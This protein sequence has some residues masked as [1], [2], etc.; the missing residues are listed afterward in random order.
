MG[1]G[2]PPLS[3]RRYWAMSSKGEH[4]L[5]LR[6]ASIWRS[7]RAADLRGQGGVGL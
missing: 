4:R 7:R 5:T 6:A 1:D 2:M 3:M